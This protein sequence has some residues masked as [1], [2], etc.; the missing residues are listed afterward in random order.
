[1]RDCSCIP[2]GLQTS[3]SDLWHS[4]LSRKEK[5]LKCR[6]SAVASPNSTKLC[7]PSP[8]KTAWTSLE[9]QALSK[10]ICASALGSLACMEM[11]LSLWNRRRKNCIPPTACREGAWYCLLCWP[12]T[13]LMDSNKLICPCFISHT[14]Y[15][16]ASGLGNEF[17]HTRVIIRKESLS[18]LTVLVLIVE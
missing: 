13:F 18:I 11:D 1:M 16:S 2:S 17:I 4:V 12:G 9:I 8:R 15:C 6:M 5:L 14:L 3:A 10:N 7:W